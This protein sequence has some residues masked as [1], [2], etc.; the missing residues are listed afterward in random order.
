MSLIVKIKNQLDNFMLSVDME[1]TDE[2]V[3]VSGMS[4]SGKSMTLKLSL[5]HILRAAYMTVSSI[6]SNA[7]LA[8]LYM[9]GSAMMVAA[10]TQPSHVCTDVYKRQ[11][12]SYHI[13]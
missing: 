11:H 10:T 12:H 5:I 3:S 13:R 6:C 2:V 7:A 9:R 1:R 8:F 4:G